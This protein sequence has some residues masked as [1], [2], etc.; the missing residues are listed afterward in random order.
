MTS[1]VIVNVGRIIFMF[2]FHVGKRIQR[3][4]D[5]L[6]Q[7]T[8]FVVR[9]EAMDIR[10]CGLPKG[11]FTR[12]FYCRFRRFIVEKIMV[13]VPRVFFGRVVHINFFTRRICG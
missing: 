1:E 12:F 8:L 7:V 2:R 4:R 13:K 3:R 10:G 5:L 11:S 6:Y 9:V